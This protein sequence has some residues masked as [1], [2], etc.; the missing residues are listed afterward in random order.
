MQS[1]PLLWIPKLDLY[2]N[3]K[4]ILGSKRWINDGI[5]FASQSLLSLQSK[6]KVYGWQSTQLGKTEGLFKPIPSTSPFVQILH[7]L[8][9]N[10]YFP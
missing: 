9:A 1:D 7:C 3:D 4:E 6:G 10:P 2:Q 5:V 8:V